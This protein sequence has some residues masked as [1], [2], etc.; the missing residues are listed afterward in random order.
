MGN[1]TSMKIKNWTYYFLMK[2]L[3]SNVLIEICQRC[4]KKWYRNIDI[5]YIGH[6]TIRKID[7]YEHIYCV[8]PMHL[9]VNTTDGHI[10]QKMGMNTWL[11]LQ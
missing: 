5:Y 3:I 4:T 10:E 11:L 6:I 9:I 7:D 2:W 1:M 8:D